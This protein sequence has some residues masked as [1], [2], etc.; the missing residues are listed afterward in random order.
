MSN[1]VIAGRR[2]HGTGTGYAGIGAG[3]EPGKGQCQYQQH[4]GNGT[5]QLTNPNVVNRHQ[6]SQLRCDGNRIIALLRHTRGNDMTTRC[7]T[8]FIMHG[9][10]PTALQMRSA[11]LY[12]VRT[13]MQ[14]R[15]VHF[16][17]AQPQ[18]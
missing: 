12:D 9:S 2:G 6:Y 5:H 14:P 4:S 18:Q 7:G 3:G 17:Q 1:L 13:R 16:P 8:R 15:A 10:G 11:P